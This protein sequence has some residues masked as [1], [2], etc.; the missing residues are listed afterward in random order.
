ML[1]SVFTILRQPGGIVASSEAQ[2]SYPADPVVART[3]SVA[4][5]DSFLT[6]SGGHS[7]IEEGGRLAVALLSDIV[8]GAHVD[9]R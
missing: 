3:G 7:S 2:R 8:M 4:L 1:R 5:A 6:L 9:T